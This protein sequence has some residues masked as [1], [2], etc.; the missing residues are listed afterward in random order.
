MIVSV[1]GVSIIALFTILFVKLAGGDAWPIIAI[2]PGVGLPIGVLLVIAL[3]IVSGFRRKREADAA[4]AA[5]AAKRS[6][7]PSRSS[8]SASGK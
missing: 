5:T 2:A 6:G 7:N 1:L 8:G 3:V 4:L